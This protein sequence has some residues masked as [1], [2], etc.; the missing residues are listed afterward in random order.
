MC[1]LPLPWKRPP[2]CEEAL[3]RIG[4]PHPDADRL[5]LSGL[6]LHPGGRGQRPRH[7]PHPGRSVQHA[8]RPG[9]RRDPAHRAGGFLILRIW[10]RASRALPPRPAKSLAFSG[11]FGHCACSAFGR[12]RCNQS[13]VCQMPTALICDKP[14][15]V[16]G[17]GSIRLSLRRS[18]SIS[19]SPDKTAGNRIAV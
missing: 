10:F 7:R 14:V 1:R 8:P 4:G 15:P 18:Q 3:R 5:L 16:I 19:L 13:V 9:K 17:Q 11:S 2:A 6:R 12:A